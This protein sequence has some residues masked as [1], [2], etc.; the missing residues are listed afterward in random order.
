MAKYLVIATFMMDDLP[1]LITEDRDEAIELACEI[2]A[3]LLTGETGDDFHT[4]IQ[5][6]KSAL[7]RD[8]SMQI[9]VI[10]VEFSDAG[11]PLHGLSGTEWGVVRDERP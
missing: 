7:G 5:L 11:V 6:S 4:A 9:G 1:L 2:E 8:S 3:D 10:I